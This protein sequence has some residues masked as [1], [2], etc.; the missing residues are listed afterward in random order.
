VNVYKDIEN[1]SWKPGTARIGQRF[2][3]HASQRRLTKANFEDFLA[4]MRAL[5]I[6]RHPKSLDDFV[7]GAIVGNA[8]IEKVVRGSKFFWAVRGNQHWANRMP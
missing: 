8:V 5:G 2:W 4:D 6:Q 3:V 7:Y 1:R